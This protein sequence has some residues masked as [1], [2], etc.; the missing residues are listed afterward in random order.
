MIFDLDRF[1]RAQARGYDRALGELHAGRKRTHWIW[2]VFPQLSGLG[3]SPMAQTFGLRGLDE[4]A[5]YL[6]DPV[7]RGRLLAAAE[8]VRGHLERGPQTPLHA[9]MGSDIDALKLV[10]SMTLFR[11]VARRAGDTA[12][13][14]AAD[15]ILATAKTQGIAEC[16][17]T[18]ARISSAR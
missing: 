6:A 5:A 3:Q 18:L 10:S 2:Y 1:H 17:F 7:L 4:A 14:A 9:I 11:E 13:A 8:A 12:V 15:A 16:A